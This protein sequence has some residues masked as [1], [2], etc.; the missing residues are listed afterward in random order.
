MAS[1]LFTRCLGGSARR[2]DLTNLSVA[3]R[4]K[5]QSAQRPCDCRDSSRAGTR[6]RV[7]LARACRGKAGVAV[8][9]LGDLRNQSGVDSDLL[10]QRDTCVV[11]C[12]RAAM[13]ASALPA[14]GACWF[15]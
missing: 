7:G 12:A 1:Q 11:T 5:R 3:S 10:W 8:L 2:S 13:Q 4:A 15:A 6:S 14:S 9:P